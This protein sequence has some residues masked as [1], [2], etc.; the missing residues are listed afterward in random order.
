MVCSNDLNNRIVKYISREVI[1]MF[2]GVLEEFEFEDEFEESESME[3]IEEEFEEENIN[4][5]EEEFEFMEKYYSNDELIEYFKENLSFDINESHII[6]EENIEKGKMIIGE[7]NSNDYYIFYFD[8]S[9]PN[10]DYLRLYNDFEEIM[11]DGRYKLFSIYKKICPQK[12]LESINYLY[13]NSKSEKRHFE[14]IR[15]LYNPDILT[16][17]IERSVCE[18]YQNFQFY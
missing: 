13:I 2:E 17:T 5:F 8:L 1:N 6:I 3:E 4:E 9:N 18:W 14:T 7:K 16:L 12:G 11:S 10:I 15:T